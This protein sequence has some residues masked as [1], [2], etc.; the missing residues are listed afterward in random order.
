[1]GWVSYVFMWTGDRDMA[2]FLSLAPVTPYQH[3]TTPN[4]KTTDSHNTQPHTQPPPQQFNRA[5]ELPSQP[6]MK[7]QLSQ[8]GKS[9]W[10]LIDL[11][12]DFHLLLFLTDLLG[13]DEVRRVVGW[14]AGW[15]AGWLGWLVGFVVKE[16][17]TDA[18]RPSVP[19]HMPYGPPLVTQ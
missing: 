3:P 5:D 1:M 14:L 11:L 10:T 7:Q 19:S 8:A 17:E 18:C 12:A 9:G 16:K 2:F 4:H 13:M 6:A 15:L